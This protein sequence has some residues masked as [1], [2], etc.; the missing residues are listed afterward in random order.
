MSEFTMRFVLSPLRTTTVTDMPIDSPAS[1]PRRSIK[2][3]DPPSVACLPIHLPAN[4]LSHR[5][6]ASFSFCFTCPVIAHGQATEGCRQ[7]SVDNETYHLETVDV[8]EQRLD[9]STAVY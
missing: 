3:L 7:F 1:C 9:V 8:N 6:A 2:D 5:Y 4:C